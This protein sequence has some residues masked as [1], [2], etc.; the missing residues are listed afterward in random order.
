MTLTWLRPG[1][2][3]RN[4]C[5]LKCTQPRPE[6]MH[7]ERWQAVAATRR[8]CVTAIR[9]SSPLQRPHLSNLILQNKNA[10]VHGGN[11]EI[12]QTPCTFCFNFLLMDCPSGKSLLGPLPKLRLRSG[13]NFNVVRNGSPL[14]D[15]P[16]SHQSR[17]LVHK[18]ETLTLKTGWHSCIRKPLCFCSKRF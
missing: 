5:N 16:R 3:N 4:G 10:A 1:L 17:G 9:N 13:E 7:S 8:G 14:S 12:W 18:L 2:R 15:S 6:G 11:K